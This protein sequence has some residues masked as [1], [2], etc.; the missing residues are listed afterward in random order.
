MNIAELLLSAAFRDEL[1]IL[2]KGGG[3][4]VRPRGDSSA[5]L[6]RLSRKITE[7]ADKMNFLEKIS[8]NVDYVS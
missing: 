1:K 6:S 2:E 3:S 8:K 7:I 5:R 4:E